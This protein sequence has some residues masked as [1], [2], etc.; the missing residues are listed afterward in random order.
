[1]P[2]LQDFTLDI[3][4]LQSAADRAENAVNELANMLAD[5][6]FPYNGDVDSLRHASELIQDAADAYLRGLK[7]AQG[8]PQWGTPVKYFTIIAVGG[9]LNEPVWLRAIVVDCYV[10]RQDPARYDQGRVRIMTGLGQYC[11][12]P[13][14]HIKIQ[15]E[16]LL[17][18][19]AQMAWLNGND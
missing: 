10:D 1:M 17:T 13:I 11:E 8:L 4:E 18:H 6:P 12:M 9:G 15:G 3:I 5:A 2:E 7:K 16:R 19:D 14:E